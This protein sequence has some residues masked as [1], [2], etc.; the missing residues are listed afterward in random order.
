MQMEEKEILREYMLKEIDI[1]QDIIKR[2]AFNS[3]MIKGWAITLVVVTL[4]L[5][6]AEYQVWIAF[7]PLLVFW[8]LD[9]YFLWLE[10]MYR[11]LYEWI[12]KNRLKTD[13]Y[14]FNMNA[15][16]FKDEVQ[17]KL[18]IMFSITL[19]GFYGSIAI[20]IIIYALV[21]LITKGGA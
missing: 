15:Y 5:K 1:V 9:A 17:S 18:R 6:G 7:I 4:L 2:M 19:G 10:R 3:F 8:F 20:L 13:E 14:L 16:R 21:V 12:I 11:R